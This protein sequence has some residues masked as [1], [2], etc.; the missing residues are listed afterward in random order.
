MNV[1][2]TGGSGF[3]GSHIAEH[4]LSRGDHVYVVDDL[5]TGSIANIASFQTYP[6]FKFEQANVL[7]WSNLEKVVHW[8]DKIFHMAALV[9][10]FRVLS[11]PVE[12]LDTNINGYLR[13]L[14]I[15][16]NSP[17]KPRV[18]VASSSSVYGYSRNKIL[19]EKDELVMGSP[20][21][22]LRNYAISKM[23]DE[24]FSL[25]YFEEKKVAA[26]SIRIFNTIG[27]R[28]TGR[29]GMVVPRFVQQA[30]QGE[31]ITIFGDGTQTRSFCDVR[32][33]VNGLSLIADNDKTIGE[34]INVGNNKEITINELAHL[35]KRLAN[36]TSEIQYKTYEEAYGNKFV[37]IQNRRPDL[38]K[39]FHYTS[40]KHQWTLE[41]TILDLI[42]RFKQ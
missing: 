2:I 42:S 9:G 14:N 24:A 20:A 40:Y 29:Y 18:I 32:D 7:N 38:S 41:D 25:A 30:C 10:I 34:I 5:S 21:H 36:S 3:I 12:V 19:S 23:A 16:S 33:V 8:A 35:V 1:L 11:S 22:P 4:F 6:N 17:S 39:F 26:T 15:A 31:P 27:P 28:Q 37:D 13:V